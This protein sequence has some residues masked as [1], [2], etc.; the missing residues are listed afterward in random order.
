MNDIWDPERLANVGWIMN[1]YGDF[2]ENGDRIRI[3]QEGDPCSTYRSS[4]GAG[5]A[6]VDGIERE[7]DGTVRFRAVMEESGNTVYLDNRNVAPD[8]IWEI[9][10]S[11]VKD[12][13]ERVETYRSSRDI[14]GDDGVEHN[15]TATV[16]DPDVQIER[17]MKDI[18]FRGTEAE[19]TLGGAIR[20]L[21]GDMMRIYR[22]EEP[23]FS[24]KFA[25]RYD[26]ALNSDVSYQGSHE[27][28]IDR[29][30]FSP[31]DDDDSEN[32]RARGSKRETDDDFPPVG[33]SYTGKVRVAPV[34]DEDD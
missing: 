17:R 15:D 22:G 23:V 24:V 3:G 25:D 10:P 28:E 31:G 19:R 27:S 7:V 29:H 30:I 11:L 4:E 1:R 32:R 26:L 5:S 12:F 34:V 33:F 9:H 8:R 2:L 20:E 14:A 6:L 21:A 18:E 16:T 13:R